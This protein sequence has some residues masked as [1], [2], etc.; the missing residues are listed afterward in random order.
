[1]CAGNES[2]MMPIGLMNPIASS[3]HPK[4]KTSFTLPFINNDLQQQQQRIEFVF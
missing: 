2:V 4:K 1:M 3:Q